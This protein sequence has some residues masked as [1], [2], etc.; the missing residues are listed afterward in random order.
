LKK[1]VSLN[2]KSLSQREIRQ[3]T[4][5]LFAALL[6]VN[7]GLMAYDARDPETND[8]TV[9]VWAQTAA[10]VVQRPVASVG[11]AGTGF[12]GSIINLRSA[13]VENEGL[14]QRVNQLES[15]VTE[16]QNLA[17]ENERL[18]SLLDLRNSQQ[19]HNISAEVIARDPSVWFDMVTINRGSSS[20]VDLNMPVVTGEGVVGRVVAV[21]PVTAQVSLLTDEKSAAAAVIGQ[22]GASNAL[23]SIRGVTKDLLEMRY[24]SGQEKVEVGNVVTTTGQDRIYPPGLKIGEV[25]E[26][27]SGSASSPHTIFVKP[28]ARLGS[29]Q[30]VSVL[31]YTAPPRPEPD[32]ALP[33]VKKQGENKR[34]N[35]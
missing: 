28:S 12:F 10:G 21:S 30:T 7:F 8:S 5:W 19:F 25:V 20:G 35:P 27:K 14:K 4:P 18:K 32:K 16:K 34:K 2:Q 23:G 13:A 31:I 29:L 17:L 9:R 6:L 15:E 1:V 33:N 24:V 11:N 3:R 26:V 22:V